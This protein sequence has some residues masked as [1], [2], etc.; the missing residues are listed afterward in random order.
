MTALQ[1]TNT[2]TWLRDAATYSRVH[3]RANPKAPLVK[4]D[5][6]KQTRT[7]NDP[8]YG[9][10][11]A[12]GMIIA[13][14]PIPHD[15]AEFWNH[16]WEFTS[17]TLAQADPDKTEGMFILPAETTPCLR[18]KWEY[19]FSQNMNQLSAVVTATPQFR[20]DIWYKEPKLCFNGLLGYKTCDVFDIH[21]KKLQ[22]YDLTKFTNPVR[23]TCQI[24]H[25]TRFRY[26][27]RPK[28]TQ[29]PQL[30]IRFSQIDWNPWL[31]PANAAEP[32]SNLSM[33][34][35]GSIK[36]APKY[37]LAPDGRLKNQ[38]EIPRWGKD[39]LCGLAIHG[40]EGG[41]GAPDCWNTF[42]PWPR[43]PIRLRA[44]VRFQ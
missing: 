14:P 38:T 30:T 41:Y 23:K 4:D 7:I 31:K 32:L 13:R 37:C 2:Y 26:V 9:G 34:Y 40:W 36:P 43:V 21:G 20:D 35:D 29:F 27:L 19:E 5:T 15:K 42:R 22:T 10:L 25:K 12:F 39:D 24:P 3:P 6:E 17:R 8:R 16:V 18:V 28:A 33:G 44:T 1:T 11:F